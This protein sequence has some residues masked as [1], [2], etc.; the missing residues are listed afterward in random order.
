MIRLDA[1]MIQ[2]KIVHLTSVHARYDTRVFI[3]MCGSLAS[4]GYDVYLVVAD[5]LGDEIK[6]NVKILDVGKISKGRLQRVTKTVIKVY[7]QA[8]NIEASLYHIHDPE[9]IPIGIKLKKAGKRVI[10]DAHEDF[11][12]Q[13]LSKAYLNAFIRKVLSGLFAIYESQVCHKF[14]AIVAATPSIQE[15]FLSINPNTV[16][17]NNYPLIDEL[18]NK[19]G[20]S[21]KQNRITYIGAIAERRGIKEIVTAMEYTHDVKLNLAGIFGEKDVERGVKNQPGWLKVNEE[22]FL[23]RSEVKKLLAMSQAGLVTLHPIASYIDALPVK[24]FEYMAASIPVIS[25]DFPLW[26]SIIESSQCGLCVNPLDPKAIGKAIQYIIDHPHES[27]KMGMNG[28]R[29]V[30]EKYN[31]S[32]EEK[33]LLSLYE[34]LLQ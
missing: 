3:K 27:E 17:V 5:G 16:V 33:K 10:F 18:T 15:K 8:K 29:A 32:I 21:K 2:N 14:D 13:L 22:G 23:D 28:R 31:W 1:K 25:S 30:E 4:Y 24:M 20:W 6:N 26:V 7:E 19:G 34:N 12:K 11:P 9:L